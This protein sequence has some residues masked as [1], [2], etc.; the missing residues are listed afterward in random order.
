MSFGKITPTITWQSNVEPDLS[1]YRVYIGSSSGVYT[2]NVNVGNVTSY[3]VTGITPIQRWYYFAVTAYDTTGNESA[4]SSE[5]R[6]YIS[7]PSTREVIT[8]V[9]GSKG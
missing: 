9:V 2:S 5:V 7:D 8:R 4:F 6:Y 1:G 3:L